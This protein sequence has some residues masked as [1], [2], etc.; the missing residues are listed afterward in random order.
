MNSELFLFDVDF[1]YLTLSSLQYSEVLYL[2]RRMGR[3]AH[4]CQA[5]SKNRIESGYI[6]SSHIRLIRCLAVIGQ[7]S[8]TR[9]HLV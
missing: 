9:E 6:S 7:A 5:S 2:N 8:F 4:F 1:K 3:Y